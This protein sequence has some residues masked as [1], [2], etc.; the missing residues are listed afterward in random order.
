MS[1]Q[2]NPRKDYCNVLSRD[3]EL[4]KWRFFLRGS[5]YESI[6]FIDLEMCLV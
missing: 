6:D 2:E 4:K 5:V 1:R 3:A